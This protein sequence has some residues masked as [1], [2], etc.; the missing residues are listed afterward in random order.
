MTREEVIAEMQKGT[1]LGRLPS[2]VD[3]GNVAACMA[4][5]HASAMTATFA[6]ISC[7]T[8]LD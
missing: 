7:G 4:S 1:L 5:G 8:I 6:N 2:L 3:V